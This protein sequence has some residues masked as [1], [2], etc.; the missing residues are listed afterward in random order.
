MARSFV[1]QSLPV[2]SM[3]TLYSLTSA[4]DEER[5][6]VFG[7]ADFSMIVS[8]ASGSGKDAVSQAV[9]DIDMEQ[10]RPITIIDMKMEYCSLLFPQQDPVLAKK[11]R[12]RGLPPKSYRVNIWIPYTKGLEDDEHFKALLKCAHPRLRIRPFRILTDTLK[13]QDTKTWM[14]GMTASQAQAEAGKLQD[15]LHGSSQKGSQFR[16][17]VAYKVLILDD[18]DLHRNKENPQKDGWEYLN[19]NDLWRPKAVNVFSFYFAKTTNEMVAISMAMGI[20]NELLARAMGLHK[21][22]LAIYI[23]ELQLLI[24]RGVKQLDEQVKAL[25][26]KLKHGFLLMRSFG[27]R[28]RLNLQN[29][30]AL[31]PDLFSQSRI[32][33]GRTQNPKDLRLFRQEFRFPEYQMEKIMNLPVGQFFDLNRREFFSVVPQAHKARSQE[34]FV[35]IFKKFSYNPENFLFQY[36]NVHASDVMTFFW[37]KSVSLDVNSYRKLSKAYFRQ[38]RKKNKHKIVSPDWDLGSIAA[39]ASEEKKDP[40]RNMVIGAK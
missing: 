25:Q 6:K 33:C 20:F 19:F 37:Q 29:L 15:K 17:E 10:G 18:Y 34:L 30:S 3:K 11:L 16:K 40:G 38:L 4:R 22:V 28:V 2:V 31:D 14:L 12:E 1:D 26:F 9:L 8:G 27:A 39:A 7:N 32:F 36:Y 21:N 35:R 24:P 23:P 13:S 5:D